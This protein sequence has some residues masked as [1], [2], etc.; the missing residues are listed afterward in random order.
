MK[1]EWRAL[2]D[3]RKVLVRIRKGQEEKK[4]KGQ[5]LLILV[6]NAFG[7]SATSILAVCGDILP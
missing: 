1:T 5:G 7:I 3:N 4:R 6:S 2:C